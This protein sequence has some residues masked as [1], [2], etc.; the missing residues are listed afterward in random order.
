MI[1]D[2]SRSIGLS[3]AARR[4]RPQPSGKS[5]VSAFDQ[6]HLHLLT[7][8]AK[9]ETEQHAPSLHLVIAYGVSTSIDRERHDIIAALEMHLRASACTNDDILLPIHLI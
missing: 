5:G 7:L 9:K 2:R 3:L 6:A 8:F 1:C 4:N